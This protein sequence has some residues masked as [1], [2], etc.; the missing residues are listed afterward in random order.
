MGH[1]HDSQLKTCKI[2]G[3][4]LSE[5]FIGKSPF[6][7]SLEEVYEELEK[8]D[9]G[10]PRVN[11]E[12]ELNL[13]D[14]E[15]AN[16]ESADTGASITMRISNANATAEELAKWTDYARKIYSTRC[17]LVVDPARHRASAR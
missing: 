14:I 3:S 12:S 4:P 2:A 17:K 1:T 6:N 15:E 13:K 11:G 10:K 8:E 9:L 16:L 5:G 7:D